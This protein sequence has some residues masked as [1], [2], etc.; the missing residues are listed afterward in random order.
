MENIKIRDE[1]NISSPETPAF[2]N[3]D[4]I[5]SK[6]LPSIEEL[7]NSGKSPINCGNHRPRFGRRDTPSNY[8]GVN[9]RR[10][11]QRNNTS[12]IRRRVRTIR[13][14]H[15]KQPHRKASLTRL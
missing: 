1:T 2:D 12:S 11:D 5:E 4:N 14:R 13:P 3:I 15:N 8:Q 6:D 9:L 10:P 7:S